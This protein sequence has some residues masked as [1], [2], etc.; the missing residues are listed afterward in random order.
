M[1]I[2]IHPNKILNTKAKLID[3]KEIT[4]KAMR[5]LALNMAKAMLSAD[6][7]GLAA[8]QIGKSIRLAVINTKDG[9]LALFNPKITKKSLVK[10]WGEE[11]CLSVPGYFGEVKRHKKVT[12]EY[13]GTQGEKVVLR[14]EGLLARVIQHELDHLDGVLFTS[15]ARNLKKIDESYQPANR[16][17]MAD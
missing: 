7:A 6:G 10:E 9:V 5:D 16:R 11:G 13:I 2:V 8:P 12:C 17:L 14:A 1:K 3:I 15:K 4:S